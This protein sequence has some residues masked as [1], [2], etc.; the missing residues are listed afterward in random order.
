MS[1][2]VPSPSEAARR[3]DATCGEADELFARLTGDAWVRPNTIGRGDWSAKDLLGHIATWEEYALRTIDQWR[4]HEPPTIETLFATQGV[5]RINETAVAAKAAL[6]LDEVRAAAA[7]THAALV[8]RLSSIDEREW[9]GPASS[10]TKP[11]TTLG[12][13]LGGVLGAPDARFAHTSAH[14]GDLRAYVESL[15]V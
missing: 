4:T 7:A 12:S 11:A 14:I 8:R 3:L 5:D 6:P 2:P 10:E 9:N 1:V 15:E 13:F